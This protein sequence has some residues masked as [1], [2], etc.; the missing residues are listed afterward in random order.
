MPA[1]AVLSPLKLKIL[2]AH[3]DTRAM[4]CSAIREAMLAIAR[5]GGHITDNGD[6]GW[7][8]LGRGFEDLILRELGA[9]IAAG[10][11]M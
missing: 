3:K 7:I 10:E 1:E 2:R 5:L 9:A 8:V 11:K 4:P 6:P